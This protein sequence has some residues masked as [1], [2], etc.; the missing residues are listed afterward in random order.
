MLQVFLKPLI[1]AVMVFAVVT[2]VVGNQ[3][4]SNSDE[5]KL[6]IF[7]DKVSLL[8]GEPFEIAFVVTNKSTK[9]VET[10]RINVLRGDVLLFLSHEG[11]SGSFKKYNGTWGLLD[12]IEGCITLG[13][14]EQ[15]V[16][17][18]LVNFNYA[19][20]IPGEIDTH[21][22]FQK[23]GKYKL[24][25]LF[26]WYDCSTRKSKPIES[27]VIQVEVREPKGPDASVWNQIKDDS[28]IA[29]FLH[30]NGYTFVDMSSTSERT[31]SERIVKVFKDILS[32]YSTSIYSKYIESSLSTHRASIAEYRRARLNTVE[33]ALLQAGQHLL[34][35]KDDYG[36]RMLR[37]AENIFQEVG[38]FPTN[39]ELGAYIG[40]AYLV[41]KDYTA[42][43]QYLD[44][45]VSKLSTEPENRV[46]IE[47]MAF[48]HLALGQEE[49]A[50]QLIRNIG[51]ETEQNVRIN[52]FRERIRRGESFTLTL[53]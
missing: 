41:N 9:A 22:A 10:L 30:V 47:A 50:N 48:A 11:D 5:L 1:I 25:A 12:T 21:Y 6:D 3:Q 52:N 31:K 20:Q 4:H 34:T 44:P 24:K 49:R 29:Y 37:G 14:G 27:P 23:A 18:A 38:L 46:L 7:S 28:D 39:L 26:Q 8:P 35:R 2:S 33:G 19:S 16:D 32:R 45:I 15:I 17:K 36:I 42:A 53:Y 13:P 51:S 43:I 40:L